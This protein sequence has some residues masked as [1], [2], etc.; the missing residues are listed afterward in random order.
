MTVVKLGGSVITV[1][2]ASSPRVRQDVLERL[3]R[4]IASVPPVARPKVLVHGA[5]SFGHPI[6]SRTR[7]HERVESESDRQ[8]WAE[9]QVLQNE[10]NAQVCRA[11]LAEG[12]PAVPYQASSAGWMDGGRLVMVE[13]EP[14]RLLVQKGLMP[15]LY[16]V[17]AADVHGGCAILSGDVLAPVAARALGLDMV[18][19]ATDVDGVYESDPNDD[20][21]A[22]FIE[23]LDRHRWQEVREKLGG[24]HNVDV[25]G[26]MAAKVESLMDWARQ[27]VSAWIV[28]ALVPGRVG[29]A[30]V[31]RPTG[32][33][34]VWDECVT[35][36][37]H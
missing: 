36:T 22:V 16:G 30:L 5:G 28:N 6:V 24:S 11:F 29:E 23:F 31:G 15:V 10:L 17:P 14:L 2:S 34:V 19:H 25:T 37:N 27:G 4:E 21:D 26:G 13:M 1:K 35:A 20:P 3:A 8:A 18:I 9:T 33:R 12:V 7:I 32:T